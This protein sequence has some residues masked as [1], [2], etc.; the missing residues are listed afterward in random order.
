MRLSSGKN[1]QGRDDFFI[2][3]NGGSRAVRRGVVS[4]SGADLML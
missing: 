1:D 2:A 4:G 3:V